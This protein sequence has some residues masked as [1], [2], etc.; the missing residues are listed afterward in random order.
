MYYSST[1][2]CCILVLYT[3]YTSWLRR[4]LILRL[5]FFLL[6]HPLNRAEMFMH[7]IDFINVLCMKGTS[8]FVLSELFY[9]KCKVFTLFICYIHFLLISL[10]HSHSGWW[11]D[12]SE[13]ILVCFIR[14]LHAPKL[15]QLKVKNKHFLFNQV[16]SEVIE[17]FR[18][19]FTFI[20][21][22]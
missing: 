19:D 20:A 9:W 10:F 18:I 7:N 22:V 12:L 15:C 13:Y 1:T 5:F 21:I 2:C 11:L 8:T 14:Y 4:S 3:F 6:L 16:I 17:T